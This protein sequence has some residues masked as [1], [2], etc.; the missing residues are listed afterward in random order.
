[1]EKEY[2]ELRRRLAFLENNIEKKKKQYADWDK[3]H[4]D[5][6]RKEMDKEAILAELAKRIGDLEREI[7]DLHLQIHEKERII[8]VRKLKL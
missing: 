7:D 8:D 3:R 4:D 5:N 1:M 6:K 2:E